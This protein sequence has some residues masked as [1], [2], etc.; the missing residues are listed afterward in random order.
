MGCG[1]VRAGYV[2]GMC[3]VRR[4]TAGYGGLSGVRRGTC[5]VRAGYRICGVRAGW[6][7]LGWT[8]PT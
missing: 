8:L 7:G 3:G 1:G 6:V 4:G 5:G 2:Q